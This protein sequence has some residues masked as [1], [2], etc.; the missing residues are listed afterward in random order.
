MPDKTM[1]EHIRSA[2]TS[3]AKVGCFPN[4]IIDV[5]ACRQD[6]YTE[7]LILNQVY[8]MDRTKPLTSAIGVT[9]RI[10]SEDMAGNLWLLTHEKVD[11]YDVQ[12]ARYW[13]GN[14][15]LTRFLL[16]PFSYRQIQLLFFAISILLLLI[17]GTVYLPRAGLLKTAAFLMSWVLVYGFMMWFSIQFTPIFFISI[18]ASILVVQYY[19]NNQ[20]ISL[21]FFIIGSVTCYLDLLTIP[22]LSFGWPMLTWISL[23]D[24]KPIRAQEFGQMIKWGAL[25]LG[26]FALTWFTKWVIGNIVLDFN[27][28]QDGIKTVLYRSG[29]DNEASRW[30]AIWMNISMIS[31]PM[32][33]IM[34]LAFIGCVVTKF[35]APQWQIILLYLLIGIAPY[36][37]YAVLSNH[38][39]IHY[40]F[41]YRLQFVTIAA[42]LLAI[43]SCRKPA[44]KYHRRG[45]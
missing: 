32:F 25:W 11:G 9:S 17:F 31:W 39:H 13:H 16:I 7:A 36:L 8:C 12:Y 43:C 1:K 24:G 3:I 45:L 41:T 34:L 23:H 33:C 44:K 22:L 15:F 14:T 5:T 19:G 38:S 21:L 29:N 30:D 37:W 40:W 2:S 27:V 18:V 35:H 20:K 4:T 26:C 6:Y 28:I 10:G 42:L